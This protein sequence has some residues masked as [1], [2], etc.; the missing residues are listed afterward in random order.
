MTA[1]AP[2]A[3]ATATDGSG[4]SE[5]GDLDAARWPSR[6]EQRNWEGGREGGRVRA[7]LLAYGGIVGSDRGASRYG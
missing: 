7:T 5:G 3:A 1:G 4:S 6:G 2:A